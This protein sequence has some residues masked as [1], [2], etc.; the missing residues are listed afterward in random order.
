MQFKTGDKVKIADVGVE[1]LKK[2]QGQIGDVVSWICRSG[3][4][5]RYKVMFNGNPNDKAY[6]K[7]TELERVENNE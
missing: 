1:H 2:Y 4:D 7:E 5:Y 3:D 6:F